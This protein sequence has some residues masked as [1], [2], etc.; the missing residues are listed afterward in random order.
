MEQGFLQNSKITE[1]T[2]FFKNQNRGL[3]FIDGKTGFFKTPLINSAIK[4]VEKDFLTFKI[5]CFEST[6]L[7]DIFLSL[8]E[9]LKK[10]S[11]QKKVTF[12]KIE[13]NS[14]SQRINKYLSHINIPSIIVIDS[15]QNVF[16][17]KNEKEKQEIL[18]FIGHLNSMNKFKIVLVSSY[19]PENI[20]EALEI[21]NFYLPLKMTMESF[22]KEQTQQYFENEGINNPPESL[23]N[24]HEISN[25]NPTYT[26]VT[27]NI[28]TTLKISLQSL[29]NEFETKKVSFED[30][31]LQK[32]TTFVPENVKKSLNELSLFNGGLTTTFLENAGFFTKEQI[33]YMIEK[34]LLTG[35]H[36]YIYLKSYLKKYLQKSLTNLEKNKIHTLWRDFYLSQ[37]PA[38]PNDRIILISR[39]TMR[40][41][42]EY[43]SHFI[44]E[45]RPKDTEYQDL[46]LMSYLNSNITS[47]N[48]KN[49]NLS[50][51][52][53]EN[54]TSKK[55]PKSPPKSSKTKTPAGLEQYEL[56]KDELA[57]FNVPF[58][59]NKRAENEETKK[60][61]RT[62]EQREEQEK[63]EQKSI[64]ETL[65]LAHTFE[66]VHNFETAAKLYLNALDQKEDKEF[67]KYHP[68]ILEKLAYY[69]KK[70]NKTTEAIDFYNNLIDLYSKKQETEKMNEIRL[71]I[72][73]IYQETYKIN[74]ARVIYENFINPKSTASE[75][76]KLRS[77]IEMAD[78]EE[79]L[80]NTE[81]A[82]E[83]YKKAFIL[84]EAIND[85]TLKDYLSEAYFKYALILDDN[86]NTQAALDFYQKCV[87]FT[88]KPSAYLS[89]AYS[90][91][92]EI[93]KESGNLN[94]ALEYFK[95]SLKT[96]LENSNNEGVYYICRK[97]AN[98]YEKTN[99]EQVLN[100]L[101][102]A[103]SAA[104]RTKEK[105]YIVAACKEL[106]EY[107]ASKNETEKAKK[108]FS[109]AQDFENTVE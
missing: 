54:S 6:S 105:I 49:T 80:D 73:K 100:W 42:I 78:I 40:S 62:F 90:N 5:K 32:L 76:I 106:G 75:A 107:Y 24:F 37:L 59:L 46:S 2:E 19:F 35:E 91:I 10:Y 83:F 31:L 11:Q 29:L 9:D 22:T 55:R 101:L 18:R 57:L 88:E 48:I 45:Q 74:H 92:G 69:C 85:E 16:E 71:E 25:G 94:K 66:E 58:D 70:M 97:I 79:N 65:E 87:R 41:Q 23:N 102:K 63:P 30:Y 28:I 68:L 43:H 39:N 60:L 82:V 95:L 4:N 84:N 89:S 103:L 51:E 36:G 12:T 99:P 15:L 93:L 61:N 98:T 104:K 17:K 47:W 64:S 21:N 72:A 67:E 7:D 14:L 108:A 1:L 13:T 3:C 52:E 20:N 50:D 8:F 44:T 26:Y 86:N 81:K 109:M 96:D 38:K 56:T 27:A 53:N 77:Y 34:G 33:S